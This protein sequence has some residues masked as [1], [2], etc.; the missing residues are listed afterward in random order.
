MFQKS[1]FAEIFTFYIKQVSGLSNSNSSKYRLWFVSVIVLSLAWLTSLTFFLVQYIKSTSI[2]L[3]DKELVETNADSDR[4]EWQRSLSWFDSQYFNPLDPSNNER[5]KMFLEKSADSLMYDTLLLVFLILTPLLIILLGKLLR[6]IFSSKIEQNRTK[7]LSILSGDKTQL[8]M[9]YH[10]VQDGKQSEPYTFE[11][12]REMRV[13]EDDLV[14]RIGLENWRPAKELNELKSILVYTPPAIPNSITTD[15]PPLPTTI[16]IETPSESIKVDVPTTMVT[17]SEKQLLFKIAFIVI[18]ALLVGVLLKL[19]G[20]PYNKET[21]DETFYET[22][23]IV[24]PGELECNTAVEILSRSNTSKQAKDSAFKLLKQ[25]ELMGFLPSLVRL[26]N[27]YYDT[28]HYNTAKMYY[29]MSINSS[30]EQNKGYSYHNLGTVYY[31]TLDYDS[32]FTCF[33][34]AIELGSKSSYS[35]IGDMYENGLYVNEDKQKAF[36][37]YKM[38]LNDLSLDLQNNTSNVLASSILPVARCFENGI[39]VNKNLDS[40]FYYYSIIKKRYPKGYIWSERASVAL[41][42]LN[43]AKAAKK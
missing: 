26:G 16:T 34:S 33:N 23:T 17:K 12:L 20:S 32:A 21:D 4:W 5:T 31:Q 39:G 30:D 6:W 24:T 25:S 37:Y 38:A 3:S 18:G 7:E 42:R 22:V 19:L 41:E 43:Q 28:Y 27:M 29:K 40:A 14:W 1:L 10:L 11:Q 9:F 2:Y 13:K 35:W 15:A 8:T 36:Q